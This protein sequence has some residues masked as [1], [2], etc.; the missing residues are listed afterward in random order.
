[1]LYKNLFVLRVFTS[2]SS[3]GVIYNETTRHKRANYTELKTI[4]HHM[5]FIINKTQG[6]K[7]MFCSSNTAMTLIHNI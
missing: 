4:G 1:M 2:K 6:I 5:A 3:C 7:S